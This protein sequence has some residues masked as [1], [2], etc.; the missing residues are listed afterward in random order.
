MHR[1]RKEKQHRRRK[2]KQRRSRKE[3]QHRSRKEKQRRRRVTGNKLFLVDQ[4]YKK[5]YI[6]V[7]EYILPISLEA[8]VTTCW[9]R[10]EHGSK[11]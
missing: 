4:F 11:T 5:R 3:K 9:S 1:R 6:L 2:E 10:E 8:V 7:P